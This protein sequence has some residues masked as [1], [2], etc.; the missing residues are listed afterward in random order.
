[1]YYPNLFDN[2]FLYQIKQLSVQ[3]Q[4]SIRYF[5]ALIIIFF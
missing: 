3:S 4:S 5:N 1:M 2:V